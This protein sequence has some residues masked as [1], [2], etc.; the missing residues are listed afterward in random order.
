MPRAP[1]AAIPNATAEIVIG[2]GLDLSFPTAIS[3][4]RWRRSAGRT[5]FGV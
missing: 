4:A 1:R 3:A 2:F 5:R